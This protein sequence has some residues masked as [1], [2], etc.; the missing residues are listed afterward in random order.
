MQDEQCDVE[1]DLFASLIQ[2]WRNHSK[3]F[4]NRQYAI[5]DFCCAYDNAI[6]K[7]HCKKSVTEI[8]TESE[9][10]AIADDGEVWD[11]KVTDNKTPVGS[12]FPENNHPS[13]PRYILH[14]NSA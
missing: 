7:H 13:K 4:W 8:K 10:P 3:D 9:L 12:Q 2:N 11:H 6:K 14:N 1:Q 5:R